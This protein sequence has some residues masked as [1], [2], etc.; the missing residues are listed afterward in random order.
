MRPTDD[1]QKED[2]LVIKEV[3]TCGESSLTFAERSRSL[4]CRRQVLKT[5]EVLPDNDG[6]GDHEWILRRKRDK[7]TGKT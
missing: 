6:I 2:S 3:K 5:L 7:A 1:C 4:L